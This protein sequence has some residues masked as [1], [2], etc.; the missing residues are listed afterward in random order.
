MRRL[1]NEWKSLGSARFLQVRKQKA[2]NKIRSRYHRT[3]G[4]KLIPSR[5]GVLM[6]ANWSDTTFRF[7]I[8]A[9]YGYDLHDLLMEY[10]TD[11]TFMDIGANQGLYSLIACNNPNCKAV[12]AFEPMPDTFDLL[13]K[14]ISA[15]QLEKKIT[16][17][18]AAISSKNGTATLTIDPSH[19]GGATLHGPENSS[20]QHTVSVALIDHTAVA[21][22]VELTG[23]IIVKVDV[24]GHEETVFSE[25]ALTE[26]AD[27]LTLVHYEVDE[28]WVDPN[29]L[30][31]ILTNLG[32]KQFE[33]FNS[34]RDHHYDVIAR[35]PQ[36]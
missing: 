4:T 35:K 32:F 5:Y 30:Q 15:N 22:K 6:T 8:D 34:S 29:K 17:I 13:A 20:G 18:N 27:R 1:I 2:A 26:F 7:C 28:N 11:F 14:N 19:T 31:R 36:N 12:Y 25:L 16:A 3:V 9:A 33:K 21:A 24:E 23:D 10:P